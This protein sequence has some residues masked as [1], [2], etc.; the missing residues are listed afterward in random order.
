MTALRDLFLK[1][2]FLDS[3]SQDLVITSTTFLDNFDRG[4]DQVWDERC[5]PAL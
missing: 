4:T 2:D 1:L 3:S 5:K